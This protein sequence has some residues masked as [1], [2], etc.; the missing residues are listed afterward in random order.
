MRSLMKFALKAGLIDKNPLDLI[1]NLKVSKPDIDPLSM[2]EVNRFLEVVEPFYRP[3][4]TVAFFTG[5]RFGEMAGLK[6]K[7]VDYKLGVIKVRETRVRGEEGRPKTA[8]SVRD[9]KILPPVIEALR[10]QRKITMGRSDYVFLNQKGRPLLPNSINYHIWKPALKKAGLK[11]RSLYQT[12]HTF[13][14]LMLD[15]GEHPGWVM[16]MMGHSTMKMI[17]ECYYKH[18]KNY[19]QEEGKSFMT[20]AYDAYQNK[21]AGIP[22]M[23]EA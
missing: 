20:N 13:A 12:R 16:R 3:F 11:P 19:Q 9:V 2:D 14:T 7:N 15:S 23:Q 5:M 4:F 21:L 22:D 10:D 17:L 1:E 6:W 8:G 18:I